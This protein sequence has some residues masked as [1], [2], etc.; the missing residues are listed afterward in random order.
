M[1]IITELPKGALTLRPATEADRLRAI[2][3]FPMWG[4]EDDGRFVVRLIS[5]RDVGDVELRD[6]WETCG[7]AEGPVVDVRRAACGA[8][9]RCAGEFRFA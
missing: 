4:S 8:G 6:R 1:S 2:A 7:T 5:L 3:V 9:C